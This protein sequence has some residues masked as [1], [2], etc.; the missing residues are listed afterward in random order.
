MDGFDPM[1]GELPSEETIAQHALRAAR[2]E[3]QDR[4]EAAMGV[5]LTSIYQKLAK[6]YAHITPVIEQDTEGHHTLPGSSAKRKFTSYAGLIRKVRKPLLDQGIIIRH[7]TDRVFQMGDGQAKVAWLTVITD[8]IDTESG[9][10]ISSELSLPIARMDPQ[11]VGIAVSYGKR[12]T[13]ISVLGVA[14]GD[15][16]EDDDAESAMPRDMKV[17][18]DLDE[19][20]R[21]C[22]ENETEAEANKWKAAVHKRLQD[23][24]PE[25]YET[26]KAAFQQHVKSL[27]AKVASGEAPAQSTSK[28]HKSGPKNRIAATHEAGSA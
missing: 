7:R 22:R 23:L 16:H 15:P 25:D 11:A 9:Q 28:P 8:L 26:V 19:L 17:E 2:E 13:L 10:V 6:A 27:R 18:S 24:A 12:Y 3:R 4:R 5:G 1:T 21:E 14:S 20:L